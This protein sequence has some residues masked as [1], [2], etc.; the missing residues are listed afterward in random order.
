MPL[1]E[2]FRPDRP[3]A[4]GGKVVRVRLL[5]VRD[6]AE[7]H[8]WLHARAGDPVAAAEALDRATTPEAERRAALRA[9]YLA[10]EAAAGEEAPPLPANPGER[11]LYLEQVI[12]LATDR[13]DPPVDPRA[14][15]AGLADGGPAALGRLFRLAFGTDPRLVLID[16]I[17]GVRARKGDG[18]WCESVDG[19][20][21]RLGL[22]YDQVGDMTLP[23][24]RYACRGGKPPQV[25]PPP[26]P[27]G[28]RPD[29]WAEELRRNFWGDA[30][31]EEPAWMRRPLPKSWGDGT[32]PGGRRE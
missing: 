3:I 2:L 11:A 30:A 4:V 28:M 31:P 19:V 29:A 10:A 25:E 5:R 18:S 1:R 17:H 6:L 26:P 22:S 7:L 13:N 21:G 12:R 32:R 14:V 20:A 24:F 27:P 9:A 15:L 8:D 23:Q 16:L